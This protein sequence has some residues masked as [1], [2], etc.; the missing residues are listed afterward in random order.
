MA[1]QQILVYGDSL[2]WGIVPLSRRRLDFEKRWPIVLERA[3]NRE[4]EQVRVI[5]DCLNGRRTVWTDPFKPGR[6][7][8]RGLAQRIECHSPLALV[9]VLLGS[10]DFQASHD[11][12]VWHSAQGIAALI[13]TIR[14][15]PLEPGMPAPAIL[16][17]APPPLQ[18]PAGDIAPKFAGA[19]DRCRGL[20]A[21][22]A[23][24]CEQNDCHFFDAGQV[25]EVS[26]HDGVHLDAEQHAMLGEA[27]VAAVAPLLRQAQS[28]Q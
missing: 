3:L 4:A 6:N 19:A 16:V 20:A 13:R 12:D 27:L 5:E 28:V 2:S 7:G 1:V 17:V 24:V 11:N 9:I 23:A 15:A 14:S 10:N 8:R 22:Y 25:I 18:Q 26:P 21:A